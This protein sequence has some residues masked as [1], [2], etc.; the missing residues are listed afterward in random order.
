RNPRKRSDCWKRNPRQRNRRSSFGYWNRSS[1]SPHW[2]R[3]WKTRSWTR[4]SH[5]SWTRQSYFVK[6]RTV[7]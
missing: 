4:S 7:D 5:R 6:K 2:S 1:R 3:S